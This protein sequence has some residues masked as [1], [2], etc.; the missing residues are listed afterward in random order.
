MLWKCCTQYANKFGNLNRDSWPQD[1]KRSVVMP[2]PKKSN[3]KECTNYHTFALISHASKVLLKPFKLAFN[4][5]WTENFQMYKLGFEEPEE[6]EIKLPT[7][8]E[9][10]R[11]Q[12]NYR[13]TPTSASLTTKAFDSVNHNKLWKIL[14][15]TRVPDYLTCL[16]RNLF[17]DQKAKVRTRP[18]KTG[19]F[20]TGK[21]V[22]GNILL[23]C[24]FNLPAEYI[25]WNA[26]VD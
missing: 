23:L 12:R 22:Q 3:A 20:K 24:T 26:E 13:K 10:W 15:E 21:G 2:I 17:V 14:R 19:R 11:K 9:S 4:S 18:G 16:L 7:F 25:M 6:L 1:W 8:V 5:T